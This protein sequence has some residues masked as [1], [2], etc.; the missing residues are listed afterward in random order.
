[1]P[2]ITKCKG[3]GCE[4]KNTCYRFTATPSLY[5]SYFTES[6]IK[7][8]KCEYYINHN[9]LP[10]W[11]KNILKGAELFVKNTSDVLKKLSDE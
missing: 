7:D 6:P 5:Q 1:M 8:N 9:R 11:E 4:A 10:K 2:D 3:E